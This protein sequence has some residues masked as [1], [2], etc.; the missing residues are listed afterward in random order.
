VQSCSDYK[1]LP[2]LAPRKWQRMTGPP[3]NSPVRIDP[4]EDCVAGE[5]PGF[6]RYRLGESKWKGG[7][8]ISTFKSLTAPSFRAKVLAG[9]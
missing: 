7:A 1:E 6:P 4:C 8:S 2:L 9:N 5:W 3:A